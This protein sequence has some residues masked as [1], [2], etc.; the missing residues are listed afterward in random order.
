MT[1]KL[2]VV[3]V[4]SGDRDLLL[5]RLLDGGF[6]VT[7]FSS[8]GGFLRRRSFTILIGVPAERLG[9]ALAL[10]RQM[11]STP[12]GADEHRATIFVIEAGQSVSI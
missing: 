2:V 3:I 8:L 11:C 7:E 5:R 4:R 6:R 12:P 10:I 1:S 9:E